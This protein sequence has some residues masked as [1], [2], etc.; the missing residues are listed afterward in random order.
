[1]ADADG[2]RMSE[3]N[4]FILYADYWQH[5]QLLSMEERGELIT[6]IFHYIESGVLPD[7][8]GGL[9]MA[10]SFIRAQIDRD[11]EK[12]EE[13]KHARSEAGKLGGAPTGNQNARK[14]PKQPNA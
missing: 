11:Q 6:A 9:M 7:F 10:F 14:Q 1:M 13:V 12:W 4:S 2:K 8:P 3:K 5:L